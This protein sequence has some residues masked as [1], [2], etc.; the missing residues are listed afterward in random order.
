M[1]YMV[2]LNW[3]DDVLERAFD[4]IGGFFNVIWSFLCSI[5]YGLITLMFNIFTKLTQMD[6]LDAGNININGIYQRMT[7]IITIIMIFYITFEFI[8]YVLQPDTINDKEKGAEGI[9]KRIVIAILLIRGTERF[10][11]FS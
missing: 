11:K 2:F 3:I 6:I 1:K 4:I 5:I 7:M 9:I 8:K 10:E